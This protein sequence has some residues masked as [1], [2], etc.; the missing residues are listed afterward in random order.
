[1]RVSPL[2]ALLLAMVIIW[3]ANYSIVKSAI[4]NVPPLAFNAARLILASAVFA[5]AL[6]IRHR[7]TQILKSPDPQI[8]G[9]WQGSF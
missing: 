5:A 2:D 9:S 6:W 3:G 7:R 8:S 1:M 4:R